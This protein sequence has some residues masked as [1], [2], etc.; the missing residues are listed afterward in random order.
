MTTPRVLKLI[1]KDRETSWTFTLALC[2][3]Y[4]LFLV[5]MHAHHEMWRDEVHAWTLARLAQNFRELVTGDRVYEGHPPLWFWYLRVWTWVTKSVWGLQVATIFPATGAAILLARYA[6][7]PR[8]VKVPLLFSFH[9]GF[10]FTVMSRNYVLGWFLLCWFCAAYHP[11]RLRH[12]VLACAL[13]LLSMTSFYGLVMSF[14]LLM[15][16]LLDQLRIGLTSRSEAPPSEIRLSISPRILVTAVI[17]ASAYLWVVQVINPP[18]PNPYSSGFF[19]DAV[20]PASIHDML[21]RLTA[22]Y[23]PWR[24]FDTGQFWW[25]PYSFWDRKEAWYNYTGGALFILS[26]LALLPSWRLIL[27]YL[28]AIAVMQIFQ[29]ARMEGS[30]RHWGHYLMIFVALCWL[31][32]VRYPKRS[33]WVSTV[34]LAAVF[35]IQIEGFIVATVIDT[36]DNFSGAHETAAFIRKAGLEDLPIV[37]GPD[38]VVSTITGTLRRDFFA[39]ETE[40]I[41]QTIAFHSRRR[42]FSRERLLE[43]AVSVSRE[44]GSRVLMISNQDLPEAPAGSS[45]DLIFTSK[46]GAIGDEI[47]RVYALQVR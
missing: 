20:T 11:L 3:P 36:R 39:C 41:N 35:L 15:Y 28:G 30:P 5:W 31:L 43:K 17:A 38:A 1:A 45:R 24:K 21:Y 37:A 40:E 22:G 26:L 18:D 34:V 8:F 9:Y 23:L 13:A 14:F 33:H 25:E 32:R 46:P 27:A 19:F 2:I 29:Q 4:F 47:F 10:E 7:F 12:W 44:R 16:L 42:P 6:P